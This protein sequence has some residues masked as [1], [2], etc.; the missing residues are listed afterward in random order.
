MH[1]LVAGASGFLGRALTSQLTAQGHDVIRLTRKDTTTP[2][3]ASWD[4]AQG[5]LDI[6]LV[7]WADVVVNLAGTPLYRLRWTDEARREFVESR[8]G[9][10]RLLAET[11]ARSPRRPA[12]LAQSGVAGYGSRG[13]EVIT[14]ETPFDADTFMGEV[15]RLWEAAARPAA[16]AG[17]RVVHLRTAPVLDRSGGVFRV[18]LPAF[19]AGIA[20]PIGKGEQYFPII[21][22]TDW[23]GATGFLA[24]N[25][26]TSGAYNLT[27]PDPVTNREFTKELGRA[28]HRPTVL[29]VPPFAAKKAAGPVG[30]EVVASQRVEPRRLLQD[31]YA[32]AHLDVRSIIAD[33]LAR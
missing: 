17:A 14:E 19:R 1:F 3:T 18:M 31:G 32:F 33:A 15:C 27:G 4:P 21:S 16:D 5:R 28:V 26:S 10:T 2:G 23:V 9:T 20:G 25:E 8:T 7:S 24:R 6:E 29:P 11:I 30:T 22:L 13:D 12:L